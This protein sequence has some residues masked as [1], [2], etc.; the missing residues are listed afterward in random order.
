MSSLYKDRRF[1]FIL[2]ANLLSSIGSGITMIAVPWLLVSKG[3]GATIFGYAT[4]VMTLINFIMAPF[5]GQW[6]DRFSRKKLLMLGELIGFLIILTFAIIGFSGMDYG[7]WHYMILYG[8]GSFYYNLFYPGMFA[9]NQEIF[10]KS[11][12][13]SLNGAME[14]QGQLSSV[15]AGALAAIIIDK[16]NLEWLLLLDATT[17]LSAFFLFWAIPYVPKTIDFVRS[18]SFWVKLTEGYRYMSNRPTLFVFLM[19]SF[20]PFIGVMVT[21][22]LFPVYLADVLKVEGSIYGA[23]S[24]FYGVGAVFAGISIPFLSNKLGNEKSIVITASIYTIGISLIIFTNIIPM[25]LVLIS[26]LAFGNAGTRVA[27]NSYLMDVVPN[28]IVGR[29]DSLFRTVG[30]AIR[31]LLL[32]IFTYVNSTFEVHFSFYILAT[33]LIFSLFLIILTKN[34][35][36]IPISIKMKELGQN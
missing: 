33:L 21:N 31:V 22:Y 35:S 15:I 30:L 11:A 3:D 18:D 34:S 8:I 13:K 16:I 36:K 26:L 32:S 25:Y 7:N 5:I 12:Y 23:Q 9:L 20:M 27:R 10:P 29:V 4:I 6:V 28:E 1:Y 14:I 2:A 17:Y 24:M 19:A